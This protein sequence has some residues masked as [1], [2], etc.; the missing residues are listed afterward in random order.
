MK[1]GTHVVEF[2]LYLTLHFTVIYLQTYFNGHFLKHR[3]KI[4]MKL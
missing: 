4:I 2:P 3:F 1:F